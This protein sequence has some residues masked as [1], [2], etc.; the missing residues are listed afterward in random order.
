MTEQPFVSYIMPTYNAERYLARSLGSIFTQTYPRDRYEVLVADGGSTDRTREVLSAYPVALI[1]NPRRDAESGKYLAIQR[2]RG[3]I[4]ILLDS[5]NIIA[6]PDWLA[7]SLAPLKEDPRLLG[8]ESAPL[9]ARDFTSVNEYANLL[10]IADPLA[11]ML[12]STPHIE[13]RSGYLVKHFARGAC[14]VSGAN[15]FLWRR[16]VIEECI[17]HEAR[18]FAETNALAALAERRA[19]SYAYLPGSGVYH[20]Y[21][22]DL[23]DFAGKRRKIAGKFLARKARKEHTWVDTRGRALFVLAGIYLGRGVGPALEGTYRALAT[24]HTAWLWHPVASFITIRIYAAHYIRARFG[25][26]P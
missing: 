21:C 26:R 4:C 18:V 17:N 10:V 12:A 25:R 7:R 11:R 14:P 9:L 5:D 23:A 1:E 6:D 8:V 15:G 3:E 13:K 16:S 2:S 20:Y 24:G 22:G 19:L